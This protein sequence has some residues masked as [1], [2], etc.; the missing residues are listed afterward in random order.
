M[1]PSG[2]KVEI[3]RTYWGLNVY[4]YTPRAKFASNESGLC[5]Y[6]ARGQDAN[7]Y[8]E[9]LRYDVTVLRNKFALC[10]SLT[11]TSLSHAGI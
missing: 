8:G 1:F 7:S 11:S 5:I 4:L 2:A 6:P 9:S 3:Q 10:V